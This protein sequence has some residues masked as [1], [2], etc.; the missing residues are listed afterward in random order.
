[1]RL[2][3]LVVDEAQ[4]V[5]PSK[6]SSMASRRP[7]PETIARVAR[8]STFTRLPA[9]AEDEEEADADG[10]SLSP[11]WRF[12]STG[13]VRPL[14]R[15]ENALGSVEEREEDSSGLDDSDS[16]NSDWSIHS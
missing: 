15:L 2:R 4:W 5:I 16:C 12:S 8:R 10:V 14:T 7:S 1:M 13:V 9:V 3:D 11:A 6:R